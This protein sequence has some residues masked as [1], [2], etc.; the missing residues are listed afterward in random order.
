MHRLN[1][2]SQIIAVLKR[3]IEIEGTELVREKWLSLQSLFLAA[4]QFFLVHPEAVF[5]S[6]LITTCQHDR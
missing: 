6:D 3:E 1:A 2:D 4:V 5:T